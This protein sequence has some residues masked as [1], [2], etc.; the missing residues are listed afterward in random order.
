MKALP[1]HSNPLSLWTSLLLAICAA[2]LLLTGCGQSGTS[3]GTG[4]SSPGSPS[5]ASGPTFNLIAGSEC[6]AL[7][8]L[9]DQFARDHNA[10]LNVQYEGSLDISQELQAADTPTADA[11][12]PSNSLWLNL[13]DTHHRVKDTKSI[14]RTYVVFGVKRSIAQRLGWIGKPVTVADILQA[15]QAGKLRYM[16]TS[17]TQSNSGASAY[18]GYLYAF[19][20][21]PETLKASDLSRPDVQRKIKA[22]LGTVNR[23]AGSSGFLQD[24]FL[25]KYDDYDGMV[26]YESVI[27]DTNQKL[28]QQGRE[29]LQVIY[30]QD[31]LAI[32]DYP[33]GYIDHGDP[34]KAKLF[35]ALQTYLLSQ[36]AQQQIAALGWR[37]SP[38]GMQIAKADPAVF[39]PAWGIDTTR[40]FSP[41]KFPDAS[42]IRL[43]LDLYQTTFRKPSF[44]IYCLDYSGSMGGNGGSDQL[45]SGMRQ[46]L[47]QDQARH[48]LLQA[49]VRDIS[50]VIPFSDHDLDEWR[51]DGS[52][53][54]A[55]QALW[56]KINALQPDGST[57][58]YGTLDRSLTI[59][60]QTPNLEDYSPAIILMTDGQDN[61]GQHDNYEAVL[62]AAPNPDAVPIYSIPYG[63]DAD[64]T[65]LQPL[66]D[67]TSGK[68]FDSG[69]NLTTT[70]REVK[71]YN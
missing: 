52:N 30:P 33:L 31:G 56:A 9:F 49:S 70:F 50:I 3:A 57:N 47:D 15:A 44:T 41:I 22:I 18:F 2:S 53:P 29:P 43:G 68:V 5:S 48:S 25:S 42:V 20:G 62:H 17:A 14:A 6:R 24:L 32:A 19:A 28:V 11:Y 54:V 12:L 7:Q 63:T 8:P 37:T 40:V 69:D 38:I 45:K 27:I 67:E 21:H 35:Q 61:Q 65:Q 36:P 16:M 55:L 23:S 39:N 13:G 34:A 4:S 64:K 58:F 26:N 51:V 10:T 66:A 59:F 46:L 60:R 1:T 71:G